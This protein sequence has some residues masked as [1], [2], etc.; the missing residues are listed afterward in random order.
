MKC[1]FG[2][3]GRQYRHLAQRDLD[4]AAVGGRFRRDPRL[5]SL[6]REQDQQTT[7]GAGMF[8]HDPQQRFD[9]VAEDDLAGHR[10]RSLHHRSDI[11]LLDRRAES[12]GRR[13]R[14]SL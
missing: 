11:Q 6:T 13:R 12:C 1:G 4:L 8:D 7:L 5:V 2:K 3:L 10:Q 9:K 14:F